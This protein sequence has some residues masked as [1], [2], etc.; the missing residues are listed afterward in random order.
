MQRI[1][2]PQQRTVFVR[3]GEWIEEE[4]LSELGIYGT[5]LR[6]KEQVGESAD[7]LTAASADSLWS[8]NYRPG[9]LLAPT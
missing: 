4:S 5:Y 7:C 6:V 2:P 1:A 9:S 8:F 3:N